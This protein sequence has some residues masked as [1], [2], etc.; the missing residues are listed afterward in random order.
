M[1]LS[2][3]KIKVYLLEIILLIFLFF[4]L[5]ISNIYRTIYLAVVLLIYSLIVKKVIKKKSIIF[6]N[7]RE[8]NIVLIVFAVIYLAIFYISGLYFGYNS[9]SV[10]FG[11]TA[12]KYFILPLCIIIF[13]TETIRETFLSYKNNTSKILIF[14][15][16]VLVDLIIYTEVYDIY[17]L[18]DF[19]MILGFIFFAS[20]SSNLLYNYI[21]TRFGKSGI[22]L[23]KIITIIYIYI[24]PIVPNVY[25]FFRTFIRMIYPY[26][27]YLFLE[28]IYSRNNK[29]SYKD[30]T[31]ENISLTILVIILI[32]I[33][34]LVSCQFKYGVLVVGSGS[35]T[36]TLN[37]GDVTL[38]KKYNNETIKKGDII[39]FEKEGLQ[40]IHR[41]V[42]I[43]SI[44]GEIRYYTKGDANKDIDEGYINKKNILGISKIR[45]RYIGYPSIWMKSMFS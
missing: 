13:S 9:A 44:N 22:I 33:I 17:R 27:V 2:I 36:G 28:N 37:M 35:M 11:M 31:K 34:M 24:I 5:F 30:K 18:D 6:Y 10:K 43:T 8:I 21:V 1:N 32:S 38:F 26:F 16:T 4:T 19:L 3:D 39:I 42:N 20:I 40:I 41:V 23:Y 15:I 7:K 29:I 45:I 12:I 25:I 14:I